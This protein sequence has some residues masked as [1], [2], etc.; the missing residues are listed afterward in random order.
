MEILFC[1]DVIFV[2]YIATIFVHATTAIP[3][4][5]FCG[6]TLFEFALAENDIS[7]ENDLQ[8]K[9]C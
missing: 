2:Y 3:C 4:A 7:I 1:C 9:N 8:W 5:K 6:I